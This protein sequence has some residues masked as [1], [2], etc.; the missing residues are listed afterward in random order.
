MGMRVCLEPG[1]PKMQAQSRCAKH[2]GEREQARGTRQQ[3]GYNRD[4]DATARAYQQRM[5]Q[6]ARYVCWRCRK[7]LGT[8]RGRDWQLGHCDDDRLVIHG[9]ECPPCNLATAS[10]RQQACTHATHTRTP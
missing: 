2:R 10:R 1:C 9:P 5:D 6:G 7:P 4:Y 3:R 8:R